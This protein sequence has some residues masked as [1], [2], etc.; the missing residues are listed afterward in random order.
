MTYKLNLLFLA[1]TNKRRSC[2]FPLHLLLMVMVM[3]VVMVVVMVMLAL[4][5]V[6]MVM[7]MVNGDDEDEDNGPSFLTLQLNKHMK[8]FLLCLFCYRRASPAMDSLI[9]TN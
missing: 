3:V 1:P 6:V 9:L 4:V 7:V 5:L 8:T 2:G